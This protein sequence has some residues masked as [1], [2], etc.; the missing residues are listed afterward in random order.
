MAINRVDY[1]ANLTAQSDFSDHGDLIETRFIDQS[2]TPIR[3]DYDNDNVL[4]GAVFQ[5]GGVVYHA[6]SDTAITGTASDYVRITPSGATA[7]AAYVASL[8]G[9]T[10]SSQYAGYYDGSSNLFIFDE[11]K[12]IISGAIA[13]ANTKLGQLYETLVNNA[14]TVGS[15]TTT[16]SVTAGSFTTSGNISATNATFST[17]NVTT[18]GSRTQIINQTVTTGSTY[19]LPAGVYYLAAVVNG[20]RGYRLNFRSSG[21]I[22]QLVEQIDLRNETFALTSMNFIICDGTNWNVN[23]LTGGGDIALDGYS[24]LP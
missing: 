9:V 6:D 13:S 8:T 22:F 5:I 3:I 21:G 4:Q 14:V 20:G 12:A 10:W 16:G 7:S 23:S 24:I 18:M 11:V 1:P 17:V 2:Y 19:T 15:L